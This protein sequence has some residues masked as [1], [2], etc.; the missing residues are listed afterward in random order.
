MRNKE[1]I[2][3]ILTLTWRPE[4]NKQVPK[5]INTRNG[6]FCN[7]DVSLNHMYKQDYIFQID[8]KCQLISSEKMA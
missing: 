4:T 7:K 2:F 1:N 8:G 5:K 6:K 3:P